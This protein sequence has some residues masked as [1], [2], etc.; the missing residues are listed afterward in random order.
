M[1]IH[2]MFL[3][4]KWKKI[5]IPHRWSVGLGADHQGSQSSQCACYSWRM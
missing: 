2:S 4:R 5:N 3:H 1:I